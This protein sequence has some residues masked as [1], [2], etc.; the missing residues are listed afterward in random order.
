MQVGEKARALPSEDVADLAGKLAFRLVGRRREER[1]VPREVQGDAPIARADRLD[2]APDDLAGGSEEIEI[3]RL[4]GPDARGKDVAG[5]RAR[6][7]GRALQLLDDR[8]EGIE[9]RSRRI[10]TVPG[11]LQPGES[12]RFDRLDLLA[13]L[14]QRSAL[15]AA[16]D[17]HVA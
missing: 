6:R 16:Q 2:A 14:R 5:E 4:E 15:E 9:P 12:G 13:Q 7:D 10:E 3:G 17:L 11:D 1:V 8:E